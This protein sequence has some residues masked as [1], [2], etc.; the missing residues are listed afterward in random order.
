MYVGSDKKI[1]FVDGLG[2][3]SVLN[4]SNSVA[5]KA[6]MLEGYDSSK[7]DYYYLMTLY[8]NGTKVKEIKEYKDAGTTITINYTT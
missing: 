3:D 5:I 2:A 8:V 7:S 4:F 6:T 1:H